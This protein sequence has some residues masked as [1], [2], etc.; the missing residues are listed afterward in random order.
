MPEFRTAALCHTRLCAEPT[1]VPLLAICSTVENGPKGWTVFVQAPR[2]AILLHNI[3][4]KVF[5]GWDSNS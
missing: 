5:K 3:G 2:I 1:V 4:C